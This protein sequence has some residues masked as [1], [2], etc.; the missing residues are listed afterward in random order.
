MPVSEVD[1]LRGDICSGGLK[2]WSQVHGRYEVLWK[3][4]PLAKQQHAYTTLCDCL[5]LEALDKTHWHYALDQALVI[6]ETMCE[7]VQAGR[8]RDFKNPFTQAL[9][10]SPQEMEAV[11]GP[12]KNYALIQDICDQTKVFVTQVQRFK[13]QK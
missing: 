4:Y 11:L 6:R 2:T 8:Q 1:R 3:A 10:G 12:A 9:F 7:R 13:A 5:G